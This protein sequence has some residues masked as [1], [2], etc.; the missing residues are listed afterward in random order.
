[1]EIKQYH[2]VHYKS[3]NGTDI[4]QKW[5]DSIADIR[6]RVGILR[7]IDRIKTGNFGDHKYCR[8]GVSELRE[9]MGQGYRVYYFIFEENTVVLLKGGDKSSQDRDIVA[10]IENRRD[11]LSR[12]QPVRRK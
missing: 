3:A 9:N 7:R 1:M 8:D 5:L 6:A 4:Y 10:A 11:F 12:I 2:I